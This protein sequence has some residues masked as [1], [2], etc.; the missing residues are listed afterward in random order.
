MLARRDLVILGVRRDSN[1]RKLIHSQP[2]N[3]SGTDTI[4]APHQRSS[5]SSFL[6]CLSVSAFASKFC[7]YRNIPTKVTM[8]KAAIFNRLS[9][10]RPYHKAVMLYTVG[11]DEGT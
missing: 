10:S 7:L 8:T 9:M 5:S 11:A 1:P 3:L 2:P 4:L 6:R